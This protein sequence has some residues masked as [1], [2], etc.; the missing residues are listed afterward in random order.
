MN[1][2]TYSDLTAKWNQCMLLLQNFTLYL[3][4]F[5]EHNVIAAVLCV[6]REKIVCKWRYHCKNAIENIFVYA[7]PVFL[8]C[9][10]KKD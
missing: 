7:F 6:G 9:N 4:A 3:P 2:A 5:V 10:H 8:S 1:G